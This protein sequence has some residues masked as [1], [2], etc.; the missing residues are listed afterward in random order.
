MCELS[1]TALR[2]SSEKRMSEY[3]EQLMSTSTSEPGETTSSFSFDGPSAA[4]PG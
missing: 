4:R 2:S 1:T 3:C